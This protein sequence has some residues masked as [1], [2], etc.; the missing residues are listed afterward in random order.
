MVWFLVSLWT[1]GVVLFGFSIGAALLGVAGVLSRLG[2]PPNVR[3]RAHGSG[4]AT[5][6]S[7]HRPDFRLHV[8]NLERPPS[9]H[10]PAFHEGHSRGL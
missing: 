10:V 8:V 3:R 7:A 1:I 5:F 6:A 4:P 2:R 9:W